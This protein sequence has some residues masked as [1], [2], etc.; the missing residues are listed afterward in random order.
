MVITCKTV[1][2]IDATRVMPG[3]IVEEHC[4]STLDAHA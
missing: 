2:G 3:T 4:D 1:D